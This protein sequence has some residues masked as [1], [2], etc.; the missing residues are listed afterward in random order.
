M[1]N[2]SAPPPPFRTPFLDWDNTALDELNSRQSLYD[3]GGQ[4]AGRGT[5]T[6]GGKKGSGGTLVS[7]PW[8]KWF[9][10]LTSFIISR[11]TVFEIL[12]I[13][14]STR[15]TMNIIPSDAVTVAI[16]DNAANQRADVT[17]GY[18]YPLSAEALFFGD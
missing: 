18:N 8:L 10:D 12:G 4:A 9:N 3:K 13:E 17:I 11:G 6:G 15:S 14:Q 5:S 16:A 2:R 1:P 7:W